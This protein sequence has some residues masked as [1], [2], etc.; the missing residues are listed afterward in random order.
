MKLLGIRS[1]SSAFEGRG[2]RG[3]HVGPTAAIE[4][5]PSEGAR[6]GSTGPTRVPLGLSYLAISSNSTSKISVAPGLI[7]GGDPRSP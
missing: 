7:T 5:G 4:R 2:N 6:S 3:A 1:L